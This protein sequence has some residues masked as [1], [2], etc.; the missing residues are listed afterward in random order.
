MKRRLRIARSVCRSYNHGYVGI[1]INHNVIANYIRDIMRLMMRSL[2]LVHIPNF[3][4]LRSTPVVFTEKQLAVQNM[5]P[6][7]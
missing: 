3:M 6:D 2:Y 4:V 7:F 5:L 1:V